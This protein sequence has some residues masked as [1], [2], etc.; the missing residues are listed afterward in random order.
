ML[1]VIFI[2][3]ENRNYS[4]LIIFSDGR[5]RVQDDIYA[6]NDTIAYA[7][8]FKNFQVLSDIYK[9]QNSNIS[10]PK[11]FIILNKE[12]INLRKTI[13]FITKEKMEKDFIYR[14][15]H[16]NEDLKVN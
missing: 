2:C 13:D 7:E 5:E 15:E 16:P 4:Y 9:N 11:D 8:A 3:C 1:I 10:H 12:G 6:A 14:L